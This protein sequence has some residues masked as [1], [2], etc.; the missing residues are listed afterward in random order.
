MNMRGNLDK[1]LTKIINKILAYTDTKISEE[2]ENYPD[3]GCIVDSVKLKEEL[4]P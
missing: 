2:R 1:V 4:I 3:S